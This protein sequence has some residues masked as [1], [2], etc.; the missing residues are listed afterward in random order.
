MRIVGGKHRGRPLKAPDGRD[1]RPTSDRARESV[2]NILAHST[3]WDGFDN[4]TVLDVFSG[5]GALALEALSRGAA[6][7]V[8]IDNNPES[9]KYA[10]NNAASL[11]HARDVTALKM[12]ATRLAPPPRAARAPMALAFL[13]A[14]YQTGLTGPALLGLAHKGWLAPGAMVVVEVA[15]DEE[16]AIPSAFENLDAREYGAAKV[17]FLKYKGE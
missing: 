17:T 16:L 2:F 10:K 7:A 4:I 8:F 5:T 11:G 3:D 9:L 12:D 6:F 14:P 13:D 15:A 1:L